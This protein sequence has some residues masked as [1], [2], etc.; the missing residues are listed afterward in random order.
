[1][2]R[3]EGAAAIGRRESRP[4]IDSQIVG[5]PVSGKAATGACRY[6]RL[7]R[8]DGTPLCPDLCTPPHPDGV[9]YVS[10]DV[11]GRI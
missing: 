3:D 7:T 2:E 4:A 11:H 5:G 6:L 10:D 8:L 1:V 9:L